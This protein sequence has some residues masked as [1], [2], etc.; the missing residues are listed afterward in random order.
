MSYHRVKM[1]KRAVVELCVGSHI[2]QW[3]W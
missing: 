3:V 2:S 1:R